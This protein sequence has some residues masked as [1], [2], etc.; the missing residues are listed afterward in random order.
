MFSNTGP[1]ANFVMF[2]R[3]MRTNGGLTG[4]VTFPKHVAT[5]LAYYLK[6]QVRFNDQDR[7]CWKPRKH[8][9]KK[10]FL[11]ELIKLTRQLVGHYKIVI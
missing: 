7:C 2:D 10:M 3:D 5:L 9:E 4:V 8:G 1:G 6:E 11:S